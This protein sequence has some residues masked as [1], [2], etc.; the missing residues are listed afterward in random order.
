MEKAARMGLEPVFDP[1]AQDR[2]GGRRSGRRVR[3][4]ELGLA[5]GGAEGG[6]IVLPDQHPCGQLHRMQGQRMGHLP[7]PPPVM[8]GG[9]CARYQ[10]VDIAPFHGIETGVEAV[11]DPGGG[12]HGHRRRPHVVIQ[13]SRQARRVPG[14][15]HFAMR[16]LPQRM[17]PRIG[18][19]RGGDRRHVGIEPH[20]RLFHRGLNRRHAALDAASPRT[21]RRHIRS[22]AR[23]VAS[24]LR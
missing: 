9:A 10:P 24:Q 11:G 20:Q 21:G 1:V 16:H 2:S 19:P 8:G 13:R 12:Q 4:G 17:N 14:P 5:M 7:D 23:S 22:S 3:I 6:E 18:A 15:R